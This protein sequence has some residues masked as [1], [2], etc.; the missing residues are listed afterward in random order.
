MMRIAI[1]LNMGMTTIVSCQSYDET[2]EEMIFLDDNKT[3]VARFNQPAIGGWA[4]VPE[5]IPEDKEIV[6]DQKGRRLN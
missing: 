2:D 6:F 1:F 4:M 5:P 3:I